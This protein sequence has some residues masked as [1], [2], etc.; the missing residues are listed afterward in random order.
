R[1]LAKKRKET[2]SSRQEM[3]LMATSSQHTTM[4]DTH[5][6]TLNGRTVSSPSSFSL[7]TNT[8][9]TTVPASYYPGTLQD[10]VQAC[11]TTGPSSLTGSASSGL[12]LDSHPFSAFFLKFCLFVSVTLFLSLSLSLSS[13]SSPLLPL[14]SDP[15]V[16][17]AILGEASFRVFPLCALIR[18]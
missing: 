13:S 7:K 2:L 5:T 14:R 11:W 18:R 4:V 9:S 16:P 1:K 10:L 6:H 3:T 8:I 15:F 17:T 12:P